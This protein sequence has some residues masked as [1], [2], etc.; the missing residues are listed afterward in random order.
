MAKIDYIDEGED[1]M[2]D[3]IIQ[4][5]SKVP[6][7]EKVFKG[8][9]GSGSWEGPGNPRFAWTEDQKEKYSTPA[10]V[11]Q[12][13]SS[14]TKVIISGELDNLSPKENA[15]RS[16]KIKEALE[17]YSSEIVPQKG[18]YKGTTEKSFLA[19]VDPK[20]IPALENLAFKEFGQAAY[21]KIEDGKAQNIQR[22]GRTEVANVADM[23]TDD[24]GDDYSQIG[25]TKYRFP[26]KSLAPVPKTNEVAYNSA[27]KYLKDG[28]FPSLEE[29]ERVVVNPAVGKKIAEAYEKMKSEPNNPEVV[30]AYKKF[31]DEVSDQYKIL[32]VKIEWTKDDP[33]KSSKEMLEDVERN[34]R[35]RVFTGGKAHPLLGER[36]SA[37]I[38]LNDKFRAVHDYFGH[39]MRGNQFGTNG[40]EN[41][42]LEHSNMFSPLAQRAMTTETRGQNS[43]FNFF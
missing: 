40:E 34:N 8:G 42:W 25:D 15:K 14:G 21:I 1:G 16:K 29:R 26:F 23:E 20:D 32:P 22:D 18:K 6:I 3:A 43:W 4:S 5:V 41:A 36:D 9:P 37:G 38:S 24:V 19:S 7:V 11:K 27:Q 10:K 17:Q 28:G 2:L 30:K 13:L 12:N 31:A 33:Y 35:L 39:A